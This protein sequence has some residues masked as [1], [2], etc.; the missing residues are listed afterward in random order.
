MVKEKIV[1]LIVN[2]GGYT[3]FNKKTE[4]VTD[5][6]IRKIFNIPDEEQ[7]KFVSDSDSKLTESPATSPKKKL[8]N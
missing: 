3:L 5:Q 8:V 4:A 6:I 1:S 2:T 7:I